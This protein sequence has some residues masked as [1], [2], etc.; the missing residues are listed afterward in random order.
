MD[1]GFDLDG[2]VEMYGVTC[3]LEAQMDEFRCNYA[4]M[5]G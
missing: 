5:G 1:V 2:D 4:V 3:V